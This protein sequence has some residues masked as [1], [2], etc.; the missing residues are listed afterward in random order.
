VPHAVVV[1][2]DVALG[3]HTFVDAAHGE[4]VVRRRELEGLRRVAHPDAGVH[5][6]RLAV[7][8]QEH[9]VG[10]VICCRGPRRERRHWNVHDLPLRRASTVRVLA[11]V[12]LT[13]PHARDEIRRLR[14]DRVEVLTQ[15]DQH[16]CVLLRRRPAALGAMSEEA[17]HD[18]G[19]QIALRVYAQQRIEHDGVGAAR[20]VNQHGVDLVGVAA[21]ELGRAGI[22]AHPVVEVPTQGLNHVFVGLHVAREH[23][24]QP[25]RRLDREVVERRD[26]VAGALDDL[27]RPGVDLAGHLAVGTHHASHIERVGDDGVACAL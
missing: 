2:R 24:E 18:L 4:P 3:V 9:L 17:A 21:G 15:R 6:T 26:V 22:L 27:P 19:R 11:G 12:V 20:A 13:E 25:A 10:V 1:A 5:S 14:L 23:G 16:E 8:L 7:L